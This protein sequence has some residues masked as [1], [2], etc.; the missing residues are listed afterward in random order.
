[1]ILVQGRRTR[2][3][4]QKRESPQPPVQD[5][6]Q[7]ECLPDQPA[8]LLLTENAVEVDNLEREA[9]EENVEREVSG[10]LERPASSDQP[11]PVSGED[12]QTDTREPY[13]GGKEDEGLD[14]AAASVREEE[15]RNGSTQDLAAMDSGG[16]T[17]QEVSD[18][19][20]KERASLDTPADAADD[21]AQAVGEAAGRLPTRESGGAA[22]HDLDLHC[23]PAQALGKPGLPSA[24]APTTRSR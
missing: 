12:Q 2:A 22:A 13:S 14:T 15:V 10:I 4:K 20:S 24:S 18:P 11:A 17:L 21:G 1:M 5:G 7:P 16:E 9:E 8:E 19:N 6:N 23:T 3:K